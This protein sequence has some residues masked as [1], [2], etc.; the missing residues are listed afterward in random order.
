MIFAKTT[1]RTLT[2]WSSILAVAL[3]FLTFTSWAAATP[4]RQ[5]L[6]RSAS[7]VTFGVDSQ[8]DAIKMRGSIKEFSG[9]LEIDPAH[10]G[11]A[12]MRLSV[13]LSSATLPPDQIMQAVMLQT[14]LSRLQNKRTTFESTSVEHLQAARYLVHGKYS[15]GGRT[16]DVTLP[17]TIAKATQQTTEIRIEAREPF[18]PKK[19]P[20][21][22][23]ALARGTHG[24]S[25]WASAR[26]VFLAPKSDS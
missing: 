25:G 18:E 19:A 10:I 8:S 5:T 12:Q 14:L 11:E 22:V 7:H 20:P 1:H 17:I 24:T 9:T 15:T 2:C 23:A 3:S 16:R 26:L 13:V 21:E 6:S 4:L